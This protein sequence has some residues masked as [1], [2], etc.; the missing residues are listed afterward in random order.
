[1][2]KKVIVIM[3]ILLSFVVLLLNR[4]SYIESFLW[5]SNSINY[6]SDYIEFNKGYEIKG[7][8]IFYEDKSYGMVLICLH[9]YLIVSNREGKLCL[10]SNKGKISGLELTNKK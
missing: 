2:K 3:I 5:K 6:I 4:N 8:K 1:M 7:K 10:Y 9:K